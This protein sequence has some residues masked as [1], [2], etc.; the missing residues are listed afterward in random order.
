MLTTPVPDLGA[1]ARG[2][3]PEEGRRP[4][5]K[6]GVRGIPLEEGLLQQQERHQRACEAAG[7]SSEEYMKNIPKLYVLAWG[8]PIVHYQ[9]WN[10]RYGRPDANWTRSP[11]EE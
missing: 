8:S 3:P 11:P 2:I 7:N 5:R 9:V 10:T 6:V 4:P 1:S